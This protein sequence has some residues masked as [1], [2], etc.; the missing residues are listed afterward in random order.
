MMCDKKWILY[1]HQWLLNYWTQKKLQNMFQNQTDTLW[2]VDTV[3]GLL[4]IWSRFL[5]PCIIPSAKDAQQMDQ[6]DALS[7]PPCNLHCPQ[8]GLSLLHDNVQEAAPYT[9]NTSEGEGI[10][11]WRKASAI[12]TWLLCNQLLPNHLSNCLQDKYFCSQ[13]DTGS[14]F[15]NPSNLQMD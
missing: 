12:F 8:K 15:N 11:L 10:E 7:T 1:N 2:V 3:G 6:C 14:I 13:E 5:N 9:S 4:L